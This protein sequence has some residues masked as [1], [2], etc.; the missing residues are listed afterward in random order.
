MLGIALSH[1]GTD[2]TQASASIRRAVQLDPLFAMHRALSAMVAFQAGEYGQAVGFG[3]EA[4]AQDGRFWIGH[5]HL[6]QALEQSGQAEEALLVLQQ[7]ASLCGQSSKPLM[8]RGYV[9]ARLGRA[10]EARRCLAGLA[11]MA[12][13]RFVPP[14]AAALIH[15][16][17]DDAAAAFTALENSLLVR[18]VNLAF[19]PRD[20]KWQRLRGDPRFAAILARCGFTEPPAAPLLMP[21]EPSL[22]IVFRSS[23]WSQPPAGP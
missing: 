23:P 17:L 2:D 6:A 3:R 16:G 13:E 19:L 15:A 1:M 18:D 14:Y 9:L 7:A 11:D 4:V 21:A 20:P 22:Q 8:L 5:Y 10:E 12:A